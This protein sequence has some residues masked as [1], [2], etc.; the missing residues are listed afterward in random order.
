MN[1]EKEFLISVA[2]AIGRD[3]VTNAVLFTGR[4]LLN[5]SIKESVSSKE[6]VG[7]NGSKLQ[8]EYEYGK[9]LESDT[10]D[11]QFKEAFFALANGVDIINELDDF[12]VKESLTVASGKVTVSQ[13]PVG[14]VIIEKDDDLLEITPT[15]KDVTVAYADGT[16]VIATYQYNTSVDTI[17]IDGDH[18]GRT[19]DL[20]LIAK[21]C[22]KNG[23]FKE[24]NIHIPKYKISGNIDLTL[25]HDGVSTTKLTGKALDDGTGRYA[26][27][28]IKKV[29]STSI[30][31]QQIA[32]TDSEISMAVSGTHQLEIIGIRGGVYS[33]VPIN[34]SDCTFTSSD[35]TKASVSAAG[36]ISGVAAGTANI[37][38]ELKSDA[39]K[40]DVVIVTVTA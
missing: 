24:L 25:Q 27:I 38:I 21:I 2:D 12:Y 36:L 8:Y 17:T 29:D 16:E 14:K 34:V 1:N 30:A 33:N 6:I 4:T 28:M 22:N 23:L 3:P 40:K 26:K 20:T 7:G 13:T 31:Y 9:K 11:C 37:T 5:S 32:C 35:A 19:I 39:T 10:E 15:S 18:F